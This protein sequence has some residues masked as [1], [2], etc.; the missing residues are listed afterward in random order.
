VCPYSNCGRKFVSAEQLKVHI[1][2]RHKAPQSTTRDEE[3]K[4]STP[5][6]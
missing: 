1:E 6:P 5:I 3:V 4:V 2:R